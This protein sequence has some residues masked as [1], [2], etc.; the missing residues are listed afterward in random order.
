MNRIV[1]PELMDDAELSAAYAKVD[2]SAS[3][4]WFVDR[5]NAISAA[6]MT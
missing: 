2:F 6:G 1:E 5:V 3:N 4:Q